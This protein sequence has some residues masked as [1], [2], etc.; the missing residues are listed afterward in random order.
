MHMRNIS[1]GSIGLLLSFT[2]CVMG[3]SWKLPQGSTL[4]DNGPRTY[5]FTVDYTTSDTQGR[6]TQV[7]Q[8]K[9]DY[10]SGLPEGKAVWNNVTLAQS[11]KAGESLGPAQKREFM[12]G[13]R[14]R[15]DASFNPFSP[16]FFKDFPDAAVVER[17]LVWDTIMLEYFG[18]DQFEHLN[19]N[20]VYHLSTDQDVNMPGVGSFHNKDVQ[21]MWTGR[22]RRNGQECALIEY[23]AFFN[24]LEMAVGGMTLKGRSNYWGQIWVSLATRQI[25]YATLY[26]DVLGEVKFGDTDS[27]QVI[28]VFRRGVFE[29][30]AK[31]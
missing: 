5:R 23:S 4:K 7:Q 31:N 6:I 30:L 17:S 16:G 11:I 22:S 9:G 2:A 18:Q 12:N 1:I 29:P 8:I 21:L 19:L 27:T 14:Y 13:F 3:Q 28:N 10:T 24:P 25:E 26:E 20:Q 15:R